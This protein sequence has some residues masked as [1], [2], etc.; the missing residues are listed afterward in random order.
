MTEVLP[1]GSTANLVA[2]PAASER[3]GLLTWAFAGTAMVLLLMAPALWNGFPLIF[4][5]TGGYILRPIEGSLAMGRSAFYGLF[6]YLG[7]P[8]SFWPNA[9]LQSALT[10]W[11]IV[12]TLRTLGFGQRPW[13]AL[14]MVAMLTVSTSLPWFTGQLMPDILFFCVVLALHAL[15]F[16]S[17]Q[18]AA[19]ESIALAAVIIVTIPSHMAAA[20]LC[21]GMVA[22]LWVLAR[23]KTAAAWLSLPPL[24]LRGAGIAVAVG[25]LAAPLSNLAIAGQFKF[26]PGGSSFLF[27]RLVEDGIIARYLGEHC[28]DP[29]LRACEYANQ[30]PHLADDWL[31]GPD[32]AFY[33]LGGSEGFGAEEKV[34]IRATLMEYPLQHLWTAAYA[35]VSQ[36]FTLATEVSLNDNEPTFAMF[37]DHLPDLVPSLMEARQQNAGIDVSAMNWVHIPVA[38][39]SI[40]GLGLTLI[41]RHRWRVGAELTALGLTIMLALI[42]NAAVC[43]IFSHPVDR[44]QSRLVPLAPLALALVVASRSRNVTA[45]GALPQ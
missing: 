22:A 12:L 17:A 42:A 41:L 27:G 18:L 30:L 7:I 40:A 34:I 10:A 43:G 19:W 5:D 45:L 20:A 23:V 15:I 31:W 3:L 28:P 44:Y 2:A 6:L 29:A 9:L 4:P 33:K 21:V 25:I 8:L 35:A 1:A 16:R 24:Q 32:T 37:R 26:T 14:G 13:L 38:V 39:L 11:L 36:F